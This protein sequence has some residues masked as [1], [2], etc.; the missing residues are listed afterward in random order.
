MQLSLC[1]TI[2]SIHSLDLPVTTSLTTVLFVL[3]PTRVL[4]P[5]A[6]LASWQTQPTMTMTASSTIAG[7]CDE[8][9]VR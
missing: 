2:G 3:L 6:A 4:V 7:R 8:F 1:H 5:S 9:Q